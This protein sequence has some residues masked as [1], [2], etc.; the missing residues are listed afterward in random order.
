MASTNHLL[1]KEVLLKSL[2]L[3][4]SSALRGKKEAGAG[5]ASKDSHCGISTAHPAHRSL[6]EPPRRGGLVPHRVLCS[7]QHSPWGDT[8]P[9]DGPYFQQ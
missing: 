2:C 5:Q 3:V 1:S 7:I 6:Y 4:L 8:G 9:V